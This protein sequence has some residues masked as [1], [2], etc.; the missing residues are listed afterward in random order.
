MQHMGPFVLGFFLKIMFYG[1]DPMGF[2]TIFNHHL[3]V[4]CL[5][6]FFPTTK[7][8]NLRKVE[9]NGFIMSFLS[10]LGE[11]SGSIYT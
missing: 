10:N 11:I 1:F 4:R 7:S 6:H 8:A 2:I 5:V 3:V 9:M